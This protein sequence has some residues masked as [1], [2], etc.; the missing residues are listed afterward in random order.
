MT[1]VRLPKVLPNY[2]P[3]GYQNIGRMKSET[4]LRPITLKKK[5]KNFVTIRVL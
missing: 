5:K 2:K 4:G 3:R 1:T